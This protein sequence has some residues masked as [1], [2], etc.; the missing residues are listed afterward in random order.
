MTGGPSS[1]ACLAVL[2]PAVGSLAYLG[3]NAA[4]AGA[5]FAFTVMQEHW[6]QGLCWISDTLWYVLQNALS[7]Y[8]EAIRIQ[9]W[10][11]TLLLFAAF[12]PLLWYA[13]GRFR[14]M[15]TLYAFA[16]LVLNYSLS[17]LAQRR[18]L[19]VL[20]PA[21]LPVRRRADGKT[22]PAHRPAGGRDGGRVPGEPVV[23]PVG[24]ADYVN[25]G[26][27]CRFSTIMTPI[28]G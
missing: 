17:W 20:R 25:G 13:R 24:R 16:Y 22:A 23:L 8:D 18:A 12:F 1:A 26:I 7:Y 2:L 6:S 3:L 19:P 9:I 14:S 11:P 10:I 15:Y 27:P 28:T 4:V 21:V 5:P